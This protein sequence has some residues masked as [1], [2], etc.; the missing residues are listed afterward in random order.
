M[1]I[2]TSDKHVDLLD[3]KGLE[4]NRAIREEEASSEVTPT[5]HG[6]SIRDDIIDGNN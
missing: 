1:I 6:I 2:F 4:R 3:Q 5:I